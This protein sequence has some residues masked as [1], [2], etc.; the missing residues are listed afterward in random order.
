MALSN[1][2]IANR[3]KEKFADKILSVEEPHG[4]L[5]LVADKDI[6]LELM[7]FLQKDAELQVNF[8]T[9]LCG[10]H[11]PEHKGAEIGVVCHLHSFTNNFRL[12]VK[13][14]MSEAN[15]ELR[16]LS[17]LYPT[18]NWMERETFD[19][20]GIKFIGHPNLTRVLNVDDMNYHPML[21]QYPLEDATREDKNDTYFGR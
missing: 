17:N 4:M 13:F 1:E 6:N 9:D 11:Y 3:I 7:G 10:I 18:A 5:T 2:H 19:F 20:Y 12:R 21:K 14:F 8:L 15:P 16:T